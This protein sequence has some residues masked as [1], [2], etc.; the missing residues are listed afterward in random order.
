[1]RHPLAALLI[2]EGLVVLGAAAL[3]HWPSVL[4]PAAPFLP[5]LPILVLV[6]GTALALRFGRGRVL[7]A[8][9]AL[10]VADRALLLAPGLRPAVGLLVPLNLAALVLLPERGLLTA[11]TAKRAGA[12]AAQIVA[13]ALLARP[14]EADVAALLATTFLPPAITGWTPLADPAIAAF[15]LALALLGGLFVRRAN[16]TARGFFWALVAALLALSAPAG[17]W[18]DALAPSTFLFAAGGLVLSTS[19]IEASHAMAYRDGLTGLPSRRALDET[20]RATEGGFALAMVD[21]DH[22]KRCNDTYGHEVGDQV[23][24]MVAGALAH[25]AAG[26]R[27]FRYGGEEFAVLFPGRDAEACLPALEGLRAAVE[28]T[29]FTL[30]AADRPRKRPRK[31]ARKAKG[32]TV[33][34]TVSIGLAERASADMP[35]DDVVRAADQALYKAKKGGRNRVVG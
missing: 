27:A 23:L 35:P 4:A 18:A 22:F 21:V 28:R 15:F 14:D 10:A 19:V 16:A 1:V 34:V 33:A 20:L 24:R 25:V 2:P 3:L 5:A 13:L 9:L 17:G 31:P 6:L 32:H 29:T 30:R 26:G 7:L 12:L 11:S 8:L